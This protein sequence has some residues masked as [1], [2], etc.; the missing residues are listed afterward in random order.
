MGEAVPGRVGPA[1]EN[2]IGV[3][4]IIEPCSDGGDRPMPGLGEERL[5]GGR[6]PLTET[7]RCQRRVQVSS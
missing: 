3:V 6:Q 1:D 4:A 7:A 5:P 2:R